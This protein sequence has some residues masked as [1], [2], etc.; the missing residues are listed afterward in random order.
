MASIVKHTLRTDRGERR[1]IK[2]NNRTPSLP[3]KASIVKHTMHEG[4]TRSGDKKQ[5]QRRT[6]EKI[7]LSDMAVRK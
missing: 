3:Q 1:E 4:K 5:N 7:W 2:N 6:S